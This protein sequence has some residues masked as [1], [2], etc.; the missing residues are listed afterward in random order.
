MLSWSY[1]QTIFSPVGTVP[2]QVITICL[3]IYLPLLNPIFI[4][5]QFRL[6][7]ADLERFEQAEGLEAHQQILEQ[8]ARNLPALTRTPIGRKFTQF[9]TI[10]C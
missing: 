10:K 5:I 8:I 2:K 1:W 9:I 7:A 4:D 3:N 6:S